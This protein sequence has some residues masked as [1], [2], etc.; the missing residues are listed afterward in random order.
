MAGLL[1][2]KVVLVTG[3]GQGV[4]RDIALQAAR[5]GAK[6]MVNDLGTSINGEGIDAS[7]AGQV[8][9]EIRAAGGEAAHCG[10]SVTNRADVRA[11]IDQCRDELGGLNLLVNNAGILRDR[12]FHRMSDEEWDAVIDV[13]LNGAR[14]IAAAACDIFRQQESGSMVHM[15]STAGLCGNLG[16]ANYSAAKLGIV[17]LS[18]SISIDMARTNVRSNCIAP[19]AYSRMTATVPAEGSAQKPGEE[20]YAE[21]I[22]KMASEKIP[23]LIVAL[24]SDAAAHITGQI[25]AVRGNEIFLM[26]QPRPLRSVHRDQG[27]TPETVLEHAIPAMERDFYGPETSRD[28]FNWDPI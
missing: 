11:M 9:E 6:V 1:E 25:F 26:S 14:N 13:H 8:A 23:P 7:V 2:G 19:F 21:K 27:W 3:A 18:R 22:K 12:M 28:V 5:A 10:A 15:T 20:P 24:G 17:G 16:Q 4:G